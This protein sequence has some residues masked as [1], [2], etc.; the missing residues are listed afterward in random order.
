MSNRGSIGEAVG[1]ELKRESGRMNFIQEM[2]PS[3][4]ISSS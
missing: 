2:E 4:N 3:I 1:G